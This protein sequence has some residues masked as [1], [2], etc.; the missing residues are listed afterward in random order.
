MRCRSLHALLLLPPPLSPHPGPKQDSGKRGKLVWHRQRC[1]ERSNIVEQHQHQHPVPRAG[2]RG[3]RQQRRQRGVDATD[4]ETQA[5]TTLTNVTTVTTTTT[6][7]TN[8][9][10][11][12]RQRHRPCG[13][14][15]AVPRGSRKSAEHVVAPGQHKSKRQHRMGRTLRLGS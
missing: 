5:S 2:R 6:T 15:P 10:T 7:A 4:N 9:T 1:R 14:C 13:G 11:A 12:G 3:W 8:A